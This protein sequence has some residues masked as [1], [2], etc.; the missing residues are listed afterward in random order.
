MDA[1]A[2]SKLKGIR[3]SKDGPR[4]NHLFFADD[5]QLFV[6]D[7]LENYLGLPILMGKKRANAFKSIMECT[8]K[9]INSWSKRLLSSAGKEIF[10]KAIIQSLPTYAFSVFMAPKAWDRLCHP[11]GMGGIGFR[12]LHLFNIALLGRQ[13]WRLLTCK[14]SL[15]YEVL[16][17]KYFLNGDIFHPKKVDNPSFTWKSVSKA[18]DELKEGFGWIV[19]N[20]RSIDIWRDCWG[21]EGLL[22]S[23]TRVDRS[24]V[25]EVYVS[26]LF[27]TQR[28]GWNEDRV[29]E[30]YGESLKDQICKLPISHADYAD[31]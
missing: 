25:L 1:Q 26:E 24:S 20:G 12:D 30:I 17:A 23:L 4:I 10:I 18:A 11:K 19:G 28:D 16:S 9:R 31:Q 8:A 13:V 27:N 6:A 14:E 21:I 29:T 2:N 3:A 22:G 5:A 15:C 7:D